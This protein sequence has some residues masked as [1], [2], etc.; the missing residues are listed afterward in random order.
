MTVTNKPDH[1]GATVLIW[2][3]DRLASRLALRA[4]ASGG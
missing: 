2:T 1:R 3:S 4:T